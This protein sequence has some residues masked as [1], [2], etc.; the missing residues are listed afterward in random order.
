MATK[1]EVAN[2][3][4][5]AVLMR[6]RDS[7]STV[8]EAISAMLRVRPWIS[9]RFSIPR[10]EWAAWRTMYPLRRPRRRPIW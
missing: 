4:V 5:D 9:L 3:D 8:S 2:A 7:A 6:G 1:R 10:G